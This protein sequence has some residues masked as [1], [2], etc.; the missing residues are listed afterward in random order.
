MRLLRHLVF[1]NLGLKVLAVGISFM[2]WATYTA[3]PFAE[4][5]YNVPVAFVN[6]P[7]TLAVAGD[8]PTTARVVVSGRAG[9]L[10]QLTSSDLGLNVDLSRVRSGETQIQLT[11][12]M[13]NAPFG[14]QVVR[15]TPPEFQLSLVPS[16]PTVPQT[17]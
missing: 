2:L 15:L 9:L 5:A 8:A 13:V 12:A 11:S 10:R 7:R 4:V 14:T 16:L 17:E 1:N 6:V 3:E